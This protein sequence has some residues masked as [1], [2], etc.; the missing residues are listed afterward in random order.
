MTARNKGLAGLATT[1]MIATGVIGA[2]SSAAPL[3][4]GCTKTQG[5]VVC[6]T[7]EGPGNNQAGVGE[8]TISQTQGNTTNF[9]P[10]PQGTG[11]STNCKPAD[12]Q[13]TPC[14]P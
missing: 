2:S 3:A 5:T 9:S 12:S 11:K 6:T 14:F 8:T 10:A 13:G 1:M 4:D 7:F